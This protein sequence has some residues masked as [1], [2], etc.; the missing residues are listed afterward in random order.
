VLIAGGE[1]AGT[2]EIYTPTTGTWTMGP[3]MNKVH[4][5]GATA[6]LKEGQVLVVGGEASCPPSDDNTYNNVP[7][8]ASTEVWGLI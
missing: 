2:S 3:K 8:L 7:V 4:H 1:C 6:L 5:H